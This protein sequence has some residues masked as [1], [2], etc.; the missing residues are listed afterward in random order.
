MKLVFSP[1]DMN[2]VEKGDIVVA[3]ETTPDLL[4]IF[5]KAS[6]IITDMG[7]LTGHAAIVSR[8]FGLPCI[9]GTRNATRVLKDN[10]IIELDATNGAIKRS[11]SES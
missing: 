9:V 8:E 1:K 7:G 2:K 5:H 11:G 3:P 10:E 6:G 4:P